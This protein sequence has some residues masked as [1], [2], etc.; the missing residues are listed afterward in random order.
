MAK[1]YVSCQPSVES[2]HGESKVVRVMAKPRAAGMSIE[3][4][5]GLGAAGG[6][7]GVKN[8]P[9][10]MCGADDRD[11]GEVSVEH[12]DSRRQRFCFCGNH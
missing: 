10:T 4:A 1:S 8:R 11:R 12:L 7:A 6:V 9:E 3:V 2:S 5:L